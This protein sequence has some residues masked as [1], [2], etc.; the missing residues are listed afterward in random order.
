MAA[1]MIRLPL[2]CKTC[3]A[4]R[5]SDES[6]TQLGNTPKI[7]D[8][9]ELYELQ[10]KGYIK[11][12]CGAGHINFTML[13]DPKFAFLFE[14]ALNAIVDGYYREAVATF[15]A[16]LERF[17]EYYATIASMKNKVPEVVFNEAWKELSK[18]SERQLGAYLL[19]YLQMNEGK[20]PSLSSDA[21]NMRN[22]VV[23]QG[24]IP[25]KG[26]A[27]KFGNHVLIIIRQVLEQ[28]YKNDIKII[29][30]EMFKR[31]RAHKAEIS[32]TNN[33]DKETV[34]STMN[35]GLTLGCGDALVAPDSIEQALTTVQVKRN[36]LYQS[37]N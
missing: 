11:F 8:L 33:L 1:R 36:V 30:D 9:L 24:L 16:A 26:E 21:T 4:A 25:T 27:I 20:A 12:V 28:L 29:H 19:L 5:I 37:R 17:Y 32:K 3:L 22:R 7:E 13:Q 14:I 2:I 34:I 31:L 15:A 35:S 6:E 10:E 18:Q 23:H